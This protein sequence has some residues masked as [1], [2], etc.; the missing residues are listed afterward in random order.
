MGDLAP[1]LASRRSSASR[2][3]RSWRGFLLCDRRGGDRG[4]VLVDDPASTDRRLA[5][6]LLLGRLRLL[7]AAARAAPGWRAVPPGCARRVT[8]LSRHLVAPREHADPPRPS[9]RAWTASSA[10]SGLRLHRRSARCASGIR[11]QRRLPDGTPAGTRSSRA[12]GLG[13]AAQ[14]AAL[15]ALSGRPDAARARG[16]R[17]L[18]PWPLARR[19]PRGRSGIRPERRGSSALLAARDGEVVLTRE[20]PR[21]TRHSGPASC[22]QSPCTAATSDD[23][24]ATGLYIASSA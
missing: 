24:V 17:G 8:R 14:S 6:S 4:L 22:S 1:L 9:S 21:P 19:S 23:G 18:W 16:D 10:S 5:R 11:V 13:L 7:L 20:W 3:W 2:A 15:A 12:S